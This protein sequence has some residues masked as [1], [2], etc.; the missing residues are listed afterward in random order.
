[1]PDD[2][3][4]RIRENAYSLWLEEGRPE[5]RA[6]DHWALAELIY[7][8]E[9]GQPDMLK[10]VQEPIPEPAELMENLGEFPTL[11]DQGDEQTYPSRRR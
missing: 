8:Q 11:T 10:P 4:Q 3:E 6:N 5:G 1:M 2:R 7:A 9:I